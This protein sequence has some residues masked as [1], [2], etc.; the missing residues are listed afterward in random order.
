MIST[1]IRLP[2][3]IVNIVCIKKLFYY[4]NMDALSEMDKRVIVHFLG[5]SIHFDFSVFLIETK[6]ERVCG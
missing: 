1:R 2:Y 4:I 3:L 6:G 5:N